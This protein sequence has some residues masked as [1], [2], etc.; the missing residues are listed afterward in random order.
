MTFRGD[1]EDGKE[2][3]NMK[4]NFKG[5]SIFLFENTMKIVSMALFIF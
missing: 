5:K 2:G 3:K 1:S 4:N